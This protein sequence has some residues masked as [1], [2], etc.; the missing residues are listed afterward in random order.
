MKRLLIEVR[1]IQGAQNTRPIRHWYRQSILRSAFLPYREIK[2]TFE[3]T[4]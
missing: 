3:W 1:P 4:A 2:L